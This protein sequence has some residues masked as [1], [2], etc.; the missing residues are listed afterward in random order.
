MSISIMTRKRE[1]AALE[2]VGMSKNQMRRMLKHEGAGYA[3][4]VILCAI[5][6]GNLV[7]YGLF[8]LFRNMAEYARFTY[9]LIPVLIMYAVIIAVCLITPG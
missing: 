8:S 3:I 1:L 7:A 5:I 6:F 9:P 2:S 4:V